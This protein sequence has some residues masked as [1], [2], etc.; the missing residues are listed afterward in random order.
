MLIPLEATEKAYGR[1]ET[2]RVVYRPLEVVT[3]VITGREQGD[4]Q[5]L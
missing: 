2:D 1:I 3:A 5:G 4:H